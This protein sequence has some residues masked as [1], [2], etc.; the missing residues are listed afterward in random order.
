MKHAF[1]ALRHPVY[2]V[3]WGA[4]VVSNVGVFM[5]DVTSAWLV[6]RLSDSPVWVALV[7]AAATLPIF[8]LAI[9]AGALTD[10]LD[11]RR[12][13]AIVQL[14]LIGVSAAL[15]TLAL[16]DRITVH[17]LVALT[18]L[19]GIG[20]ALIGPAWQAIAPELVPRTE[21]RSAIALNSMGFNVARAVGP[22]AG[23]ALL[24]A[25]GATATYG[26]NTAGYLFVIAAL[27]WWRRPPV[28]DDPLAE[29][30]SGAVRAGLRYI[31]ASAK[32]RRVLSHTAVYFLFS[33]APWAL[34]PLVAR[35]VLGGEAGFYGSLLGAIGLGAVLGA[36]VLPRLRPALGSDGLV[37]GA[38][39]AIAAVV[40]LVA[41][42]PPQWVGVAAA[43][44]FGAAWT[45]VLTTL[46]A[47]AQA[48][49]PNWVRGRGL[50]AY[51]MV[52]NGA[53]ALGSV[54][55]G[56]LASG[57]GVPATLVTG[58]A[59]LAAAAFVSRRFPLPEGEADL[60][61]SNHW[62]EP[63]LAEPVPHD[64]GPVLVTVEY[65]IRREDRE[66]FFEILGRLAEQRERDGAY[67]WG[68]AEDAEQPETILEWFFVESWAEHLR[69]HRRVS[70]A[71]AELQAQANRL[72]RGD[73]P[74]RVSHY[75]GLERPPASARRR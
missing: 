3:L 5:R 10:L 14:Y 13:L 11:R 8:L 16:T 21:L 20:A 6:A 22:A 46:N 37:L 32:M 52:Y 54:L 75:L 60:T 67:A 48:V 47:T 72:H 31:R 2:A 71:D 53:M 39:L 1:A 58:S 73:R 69:Q 38:S 34:L 64:R 56:V 7:Q 17:A 15:T 29:Q 24:G 12:F 51:L 45:A 63:S 42:A 61:P 41:F 57:I 28:P 35:D 49:L 68:V 25:L 44:V 55:W 9:V 74:P 18:F 70:R 19:G 4:T 65:R 33:A 40:T 26:I 27:L 30:F 23:G 50:A 62:P 66:R 36:I 43:L 59:C